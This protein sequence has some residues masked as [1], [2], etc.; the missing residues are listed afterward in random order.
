MI[1]HE[2]K[3]CPRCNTNFECKVGSIMLCQCTTV[4][5]NEKER[6]YLREHFDDCLCANC[7]QELKVEYNNSL[8][9]LKLKKIFGVFYKVK[10]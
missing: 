4:T 7:M 10:E 3:Y 5:L 9:Q 6:E 8:L 1:E 2:K